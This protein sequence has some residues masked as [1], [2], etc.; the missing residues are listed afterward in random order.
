M[1]YSNSVQPQD[2]GY[3][4]KIALHSTHCIMITLQKVREITAAFTS[5]SHSHLVFMLAYLPL[6]DLL[7]L[8]RK[9]KIKSGSWSGLSEGLQKN[10]RHDF[11]EI[12]LEDVAWAKK[13][14][15]TY[16]SRYIN[17]FFYFDR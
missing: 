5:K 3:W 2:T 9:N 16:L 13:K 7:L 4:T 6:V 1:A 11:N 8:L 12:C 17:I 14:Q 15:I 10:L